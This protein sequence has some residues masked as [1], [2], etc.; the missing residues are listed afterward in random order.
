MSRNVSKVSKIAL[1]LSALAIVSACQDALAPIATD[2]SSFEQPNLRASKENKPER[3]L[4][5]DQYIVVF[6]DGYN[7]VDAR[8]TKLMK[9]NKDKIKHAFKA[10][11][12]GFVGEM[13]AEEASA[14]ANDAS[15]AY[16]EQDQ[17]ITLG[18]GKPV[19][20]DSPTASKPRGKPVPVAPGTVTQTPVPS[21]GI[22]RIDQSASLLNNSYTYTATGA[23]V[24]AYIID[25]GIRISHADFEGRATAD[26]TVI[27][28]G[29]GAIGC[30]FHGTHVAGTVGGK[31]AGVAKN[32]LLHSVR[33]L[34]CNNA[35][36]TGGLA[37][38]LDWV[39]ANRVNP[40][41]VNVSIG[42][43]SSQF[44]MDAVNRAIDAG[45]TVVVAAGNSSGDACSYSPSNVANAITVGSSTMLDEVSGSS[46]Q[47]ACVD[48]MA[49][50][51]YIFSASNAD[52]I[53]YI[54]SN[55]TSMA[56]PHVTGA[57]AI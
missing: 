28:D 52:D 18:V 21:W 6:R 16:V 29:Y 32:V 45:L 39:I 26:F 2:A 47:G 25:S 51:Q 54:Y 3:E 31:Q 22:D 40:A 41:V 34:D 4:V 35:G 44:L 56:A 14:M 33:V 1:A 11:I 46:N 55:G 30:N 12:K 13:T 5:K 10:G 37:A 48:L 27:N 24:N 57:A 38:G 20:G 53:S 50:G 36:T 8:S 19:S 49:P 42:A 7:D 43:G 23:G 17:V 9:G 15:V